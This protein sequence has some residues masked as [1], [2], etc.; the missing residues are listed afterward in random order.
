MLVISLVVV[1]IWQYLLSVSDDFVRGYSLLIFGPLQW[2]RSFLLGWIPFSIGDVL[3]IAA[4]LLIIVLISKWIYALIKRQVTKTTFLKELLQVFVAAGIVYIWFFLG[5]GGNYNKRPLAEY[6]EL[7]K[8]T[9]GVDDSSLIAFD[10]YLIAKLDEY[11]PQAKFKSFEGTER[12]AREYYAQFPAATSK[13]NVLQIKPAIFGNLLEYAGIQGYYNPFTGEGQMNAQLPDFIQPFVLCHEMAHQAGL[14][15]EDDANLLAFV[16]GTNTNDPAFLYSCYFNVWLYTNGE[17]RSR[18]SVLAREL[19][20]GLNKI[21]LGHIETL[22]ALR[23]K[24]KSPLS[25][26]SSV[27]YD[28]YLKLHKQEKG[29]ESYD[30]VVKT[31]MAWEERRGGVMPVRLP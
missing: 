19:R 3:Y 10:K 25:R 15:A 27:F 14:A 28:N 26:L 20:D 6:W 30:D 5:W 9:S 8:D 2:F 31:A 17:L 11:A 21:T 22:R 13:S 16:V 12:L 1:A 24:Y 29:L 4:S 7:R 18:D 23:R